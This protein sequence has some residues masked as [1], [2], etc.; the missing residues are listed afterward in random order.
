MQV[1]GRTEKKCT[2][3]SLK[4]KRVHSC[5]IILKIIF[6]IKRN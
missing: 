5:V 1:E 6:D 2:D 3:E 4:K